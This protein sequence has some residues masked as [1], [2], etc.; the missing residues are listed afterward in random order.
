MAQLPGRAPAIGAERMAL[1]A[2]TSLARQGRFS[3][4][5]GVGSD[6]QPPLEPEPPGAPQSGPSSAGRLA[7]SWGWAHP[8]ACWKTYGVRSDARPARRIRP[9]LPDPDRGFSH[10]RGSAGTTREFPQLQ[11]CTASPAS[12]PPRLALWRGHLGHSCCSFALR[13]RPA[14]GAGVACSVPLC[15]P[16]QLPQSKP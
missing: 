9:T 1:D 13:G 7:Q 6:E 3:A 16:I 12:L 14:A 5:T 10:C 2:R 11:Q 8:H 15:H 4:R